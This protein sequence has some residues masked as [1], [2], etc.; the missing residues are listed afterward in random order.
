LP[1]SK[2][3]LRQILGENTD[4]KYIDQLI[5]EAD[6]LKDGQISYGEFL[7][8]FN[9]QNQEMV[10]SIYESELHDSKHSSASDASADKVLR[11]FGIIKR[12][13]RAFHTR[14][15][16]KKGKRSQSNYGFWYY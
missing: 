10:Y 2:E 16:H 8:A 9:R 12:F 4:E 14:G 11:R 5:A 13:R 1:V 15:D 6:F 3:N 7:Q